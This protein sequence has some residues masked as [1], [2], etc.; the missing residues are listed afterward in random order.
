MPT[1]CLGEAIVDLVCERPVDDMAQADAFVP[2]FGGAA[3]NVA[4]TA[5]GEGADVALAGGAGDDPWGRWL[6]ER[7]RAVGVDLRWFSLHPGHAT[8]IALVALDADG[9]PDFQIYGDGIPA[10]IETLE[11]G[12][13]D[14]IDH[15]D[16]L[17]FSSNT[18]VG[19]A[20]RALTMRARDLALTGGRP[21]VFDPNLRLHRW[22]DRDT[23]VETVRE[24]V[25]GALLVRAN[26]AEAELMTGQSDAAGA[27]AALVGAGARLA[28]VT[29]GPAGAVLRGAVEAEEPG[30]PAP[31]VRSA[32]GAGDALMGVLLARLALAGFDPVAAA[33]ALPDAVAAGA[34]AVQRWGAV[35]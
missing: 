8:P 16:A 7:L 30:G 35:E 20:E 17:F 2:H 14:A 22:P 34:R 9:E 21:V 4:Y 18:L 25:P 3:A 33:A 15:A 5:A 31:S 23:A 29:R 32:V 6:Q 26:R 13:D 10:T 27:A 1:L 19:E 28:V 24:A 12:L 11:H